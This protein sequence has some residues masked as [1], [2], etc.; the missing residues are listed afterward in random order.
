MKGKLMR[1]VLMAGLLS[2]LAW[3]ASAQVVTVSGS[4]TASNWQVQ[5]GTPTAPI[6]PLFLDYSVTF[7]LYTDYVDVAAPLTITSTNIPYPIKFSRYIGY[8]WFVLA[9]N[10][11]GGACSL[12]GGS[13]CAVVSLPTSRLRPGR[14]S[15]VGQGAGPYGGWSA[16]RIS[17]P[18]GVPEP[19]SWAMLIAG[20]G[21]TG[22]VARRRRFVRA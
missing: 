13:F 2:A 4:F 18:N 1:A 3:S 20:F 11:D 6:D 16:R 12:L 5:Y 15:F 10:G 21:L 19:A 8:S 14:P 9:T 17:T 22:A 7:D